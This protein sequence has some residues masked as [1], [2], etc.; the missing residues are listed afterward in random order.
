MPNTQLLIKCNIVCI[1]IER[2]YNMFLFIEKMSFNMNIGR[3]KS[4]KY[5]FRWWCCVKTKIIG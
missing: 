4:E 5:C 3:L 2:K 1:I